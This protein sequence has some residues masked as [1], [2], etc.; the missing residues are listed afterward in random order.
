MRRMHAW[1]AA[2]AGIA[3]VLGLGGRPAAQ[4]GVKPAG[5]KIIFLAGPKDH[6]MPGRHEHEK[7]LRIL[8]AALESRAEPEGRQDRGLRR[9]GADRPVG[10]RRRG[11]DRHREQLRS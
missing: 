3:L 4:D 9:Q 10:L 5:K 6:G 11:G 2:G 7:D 1:I 8:A